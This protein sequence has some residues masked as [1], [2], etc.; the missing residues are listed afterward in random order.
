MERGDANEAA[1][2]CLMKEN[3][4]RRLGDSPSP[5]GKTGSVILFSHKHAAFQDLGNRGSNEVLN[6]GGRKKGYI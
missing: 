6:R 4:N 1:V 2:I 3:F 5:C